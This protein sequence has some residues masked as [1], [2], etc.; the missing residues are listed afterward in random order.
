MPY[1]FIEENGFYVISRQPERVSGYELSAD[2]YA[3]KNL[4]LGGTFTYVEGKRDGNANNKYDD[5]EDTY[6]GG[7]RITAPK[8][9]AYAKYS[10]FNKKFNIRTDFIA[11]GARN[12]FIP[13]STTGV[14]KTYE[15]KVKAYEIV[16]ISSSYKL[17]QIT[18]FKLG[19]EN[20]LNKNYFP[21]RSLWPSL[22]Q[23]YIK[24]RGTNFT[25]GLL[26][27]LK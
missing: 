19:I 5:V 18:S 20:L 1:S 22:D 12:R 25:L 26:I 15:R 9:T 17:S 6:L 27:D 23:Y 4:M 3:T 14:Y 7:E 8:Y 21:A 10:A 2:A 13:N 24:G 11:S 16:N